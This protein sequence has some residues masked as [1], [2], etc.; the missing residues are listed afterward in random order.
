MCESDTISTLHPLITYVQYA[1]STPND[2][3]GQCYCLLNS[4]LLSSNDSLQQMGH[5]LPIVDPDKCMHMTQSVP[6][7]Q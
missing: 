2:H 6:C 1:Y 7:T 5:L 4:D 3:L